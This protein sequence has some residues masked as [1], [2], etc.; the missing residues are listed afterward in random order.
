MQ[1]E[2]DWLRE[3]LEELE[4]IER[5]SASDGERQAA[6]WLVA[7]LAELGAEARIEAGNANGTFW[8][9][10]GLGAVLGVLGAGLAL[11]GRRA[12]GALLG[13]LG[14]AGIADDFPPHQRRL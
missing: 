13:L 4:R 5:P 11:R 7:Q 6:E 14:A 2:A 8:W 12:L 10:L 9:S 3:R 1:G